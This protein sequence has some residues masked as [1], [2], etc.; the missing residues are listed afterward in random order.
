MK[1]GQDPAAPSLPS[2]RTIVLTCC[3]MLAFAANSV[4]C[5][6]ALA[7]GSIDPA[8]FTLIRLGAGAMTL[9]LL[10][11]GSGRG[12]SV[13]GS[14]RGAAALL[15]Y[16][17]AFSFAYVTLQ[18]GAG[19]L[20]LFAAVQITMIAT[21]LYLGERLT[22]IQWV[23]FGV[24]L[25]GF[26]VLVAPGLSAPPLTGAVLMMAAGVAW[27]AYSLLGRSGKDP[28]SDTA[29]NFL[30]SAP[31]AALAW[32]FAASVFGAHW[33]MG[34]IVYALLSGALA[35]GV[36]YT[37]WYA[38]LPGLTRAQSSSVQLSVPAI[39]A[40]LGALILSE[41]FTVRLVVSSIAILGGIA[42]VVVYGSRKS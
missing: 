30:R 14:W 29:G 32:V 6:L 23:G 15:A 9:W 17:F 39:T 12:G 21:G 28:L 16:A 27:G 2:A 22:T 3:T 42:L 38:A 41:A 36:G 25:A 19:A 31:V 35:S 1:S 33:S 4:L 7:D 24:A 34:G 26:A 40:V 20:F 18:T 10:M 11:R 8:S 5:R 37:I 13:R